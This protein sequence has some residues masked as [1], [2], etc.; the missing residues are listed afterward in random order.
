MAVQQMN[1]AHISTRHHDAGVL[2]QRMVTIVEGDSVNDS[3][4]RCAVQH[5]PRLIEIR[6][7]RLVDN[8]VFAARYRS[9]GDGMV[10][11]CGRHKVDYVD[12]WIFEQ[13]F[14]IRVNLANPEPGCFF[15][16]CFR[17]GRTY[18]GDVRET[19]TLDSL[20]VL[21]A[22]KA[23]PHDPAANDFRRHAYNLLTAA[24]WLSEKTPGVL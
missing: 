15:P 24:R 1:R 4:C 6:R 19:Q 9:H 12:L 18:S 16:S 7:Q 13:L 10:Q 14:V 11:T 8:Q 5:L 23:E 2:N 21:W 20:G 17:G 3:C 22:H